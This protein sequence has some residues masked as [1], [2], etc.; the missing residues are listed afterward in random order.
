VQYQ[1][2]MAFGI[3]Q[4]PQRYIPDY[5]SFAKVWQQQAAALAMMPAPTYQQLKQMGLP[6]KI[7]YQD[8]QYIVVSR[9]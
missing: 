1:D 6:M 9:Q 8:P 2:E 3:I 4:E 5:A 7:I